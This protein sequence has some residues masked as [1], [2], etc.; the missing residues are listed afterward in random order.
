MD[1]SNAFLH[2]SLIEQVFM[3]QP[4]GFVDTRHLDYVCRL[5][6]AIYGLKQAPRAWYNRL[7]SCHLDLGFITSLMD[8]SLFIYHH[9]DIKFL[10]LF[11]LMA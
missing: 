8:T 5:H 11:M 4:Q 9:G 2:G 10:C 7:S 1:V 3:E 6:K